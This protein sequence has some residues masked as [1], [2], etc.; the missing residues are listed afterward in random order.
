MYLVKTFGLSDVCCV[1]QDKTKRIIRGFRVHRWLC[2]M[3]HKNRHVAH[4]YRT[5][6]TKH[7]IKDQKICSESFT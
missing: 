1:A 4:I 7:S 2:S 5:K 3:F 6:K